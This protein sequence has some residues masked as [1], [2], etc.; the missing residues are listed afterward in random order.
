MHVPP[1]CQS[2]NL[3]SRLGSSVKSVQLWKAHVELRDRGVGLAQLTSGEQEFMNQPT[4]EAGVCTGAGA[5]P[6]QWAL[7]SDDWWGRLTYSSA[8][9]A[10]ELPCLHLTTEVGGHRVGPPHCR[11]PS[12]ASPPVEL[13]PRAAWLGGPWHARVPAPCRRGRTAPPARRPHRAS[14]CGGNGNSHSGPPRRPRNG[15]AACDPA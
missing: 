11:A 3:C 8:V 12:H 2:K 9:S 15:N 1:E 7:R 5:S 10:A 4:G 13:G 14:V 6:D